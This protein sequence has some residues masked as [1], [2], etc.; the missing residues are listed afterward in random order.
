MRRHEFHAQTSSM[1]AA[2][3]LDDRYPEMIRQNAVMANILKHTRP[4]RYKHSHACRRSQPTLRDAGRI[5]SCACTR[6]AGHCACG[7]QSAHIWPRLVVR[8]L[9][10]A[11]LLIEIL[12]NSVIV[13]Y[14]IRGAATQMRLCIDA[15]AQCQGRDP[16]PISMPHDHVLG[17]PLHRL[18][19][20]PAQE[21]HTDVS[22]SPR[23]R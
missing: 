15:A 18:L 12:H 9:A 11:W 21:T 5:M 7:R 23:R 8:F 1:A 17:M 19:R 2:L 6:D 3:G 16:A 4:S 10:V 14:C 20:I 13:L 22:Y